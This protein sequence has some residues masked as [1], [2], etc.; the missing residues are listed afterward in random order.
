M[1]LSP[2]WVGYVTRPKWRDF[3][4][5]IKVLN[6]LDLSSS[7]E[8]IL[9]GPELIRW[10]FNRQWALSKGRDLKV[11]GDYLPGFKEGPEGSFK[12]LRVTNRKQEYK[13][14]DCKE[15]NSVNTLY[16]LK[17]W[18]WTQVRMQWC[19]DFSLVRHWAEALAAWCRN[20]CSTGAVR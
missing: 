8:I 2:P 13:S 5:V 6:Q 16:N 18:P 10:V 1:G 11:E 17:R 4:N 12:K 19:L 14:C 20:S 9:D 3:T 7:K 15:L